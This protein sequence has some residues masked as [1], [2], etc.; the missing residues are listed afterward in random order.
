MEGAD[1]TTCSHADVLAVD[2]EFA[3][4]EV[5]VNSA[6]ELAVHGVVLEHVSHVVNGK[7]VV[8]CNYFDVFA[9]GGCAENEATDTAEAVNTDFSHNCC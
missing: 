8:D 9:L 6:V 5:E 2:D 1:I 7:K 3:L 4:F